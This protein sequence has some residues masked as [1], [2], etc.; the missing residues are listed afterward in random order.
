M[1]SMFNFD[2][3]EIKKY[4]V[5]SIITNTNIPKFEI[6]RIISLYGNCTESANC[7]N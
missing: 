1:S 4:N 7:A 2:L 3:V 6:I 5:I